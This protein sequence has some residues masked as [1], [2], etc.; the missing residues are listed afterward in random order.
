MNRV[1]NANIFPNVFTDHHIATIDFN[2]TTFKRPRFYWHFN[3][4]L[5]QDRSFCG[6]FGDFWKLWK[7]N[8][9]NFEKN[10]TMVGGGENTDKGFLSKYFL[11]YYCV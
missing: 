1:S 11:Q 4:K 5:L 2:I 6:K 3:T 7:L 10:D 9:G 8:K